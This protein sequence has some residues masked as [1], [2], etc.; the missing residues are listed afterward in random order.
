[1]T[2]T[3]T[4]TSLA[5]GL[6][7]AS[8]AVLGGPARAQVPADGAGVSGLY[9]GSYVCADGEHGVLVDLGLATRA[10]GQ[11]LEVSGTLG[12]FPVLAGAGGEFA[13]VAG[14]F[15][16][17]GLLTENGRLVFQFREWLVQP[18]GYG[19]ANFNGEMTQRDDGLWQISGRPLAG[20]NSD[21]CSEMIATQFRR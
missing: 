9:G 19:A 12:F 11:G 17:Q 3:R 10:S 6:G 4:V 1:M 14:S 20:A 15:T 2:Q 7:L 21:F 18:E 8:L 13:S 16:I 5:V